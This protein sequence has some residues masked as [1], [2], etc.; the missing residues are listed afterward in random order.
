MTFVERVLPAENS[1]SEELLLLRQWED[2]SLVCNPNL[3]A[4][5]YK[6]GMWSDQSGNEAND[7]VI[8][9]I[10]WNRGGKK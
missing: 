7:F 10:F 8:Y 4:L 6:H 2:V 9:W 1:N 3:I 5:S